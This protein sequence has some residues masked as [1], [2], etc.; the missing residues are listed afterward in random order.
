MASGGGGG[1]YRPS[2]LIPT[3]DPS[4]D[5]GGQMTIVA[6]GLLA[7]VPQQGSQPAQEGSIWDRLKFEA[8]GRMR[9]E[10]TIENIDKTTGD[11]VDD[12]YLGR[13][14]LRFCAKYQL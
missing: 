1:R 8:D 14:L 7:L 13:M 6:V 11:S 5:P 2:W 3:R 10:A 9:A 12:S 4:P